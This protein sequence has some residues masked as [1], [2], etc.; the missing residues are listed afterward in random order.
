MIDQ[1]NNPASIAARDRPGEWA[2]V[3]APFGHEVSCRLDVRVSRGTGGLVR[4][5]YW[6]VDGKSVTQ[7]FALLTLSQ[8]RK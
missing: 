6:R 2:S 4:K 8:R 1:E 5:Y 3:R 7:E